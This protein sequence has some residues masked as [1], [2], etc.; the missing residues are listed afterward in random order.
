MYVCVYIYAC[1]Y[2]YI[3]ISVDIAYTLDKEKK[4]VTSGRSLCLTRRFVV[5][6]FYPERVVVIPF[7]PTTAG[8]LV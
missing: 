7:S 3:H 6:Y 4:K 1:L 5:P 8:N 2:V